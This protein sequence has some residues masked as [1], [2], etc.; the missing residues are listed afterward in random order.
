M[1][2]VFS[3]IIIIIICNTVV[4]ISVGFGLDKDMAETAPVD[5]AAS[6]A[7]VLQASAGVLEAVLQE[8][9]SSDINND[10]QHMDGDLTCAGSPP[11]LPSYAT[12]TSTFHD[13]HSKGLVMDADLFNLEML[14]EI[15]A[16]VSSSANVPEWSPVADKSL[17]TVTAGSNA[18]M[19]VDDDSREIPA[20]E[21]CS[22]ISCSSETIIKLADAALAADIVSHVEN[23]ENDAP[24]LRESLSLPNIDITDASHSVD[25]N[26]AFTTAATTTCAVNDAGNVQ[27]DNLQTVGTTT[28]FTPSEGHCSLIADDTNYVDILPVSDVDSVC[29]A[30]VVST[31]A[32]TCLTTIDQSI[33]DT[34]TVEISK[35]NI[36]VTE[37]NVVTSQ[38]AA[39]VLNPAA[40]SNNVSKKPPMQLSA[41][42]MKSAV[43]T[44][45][46]PLNSS[47]LEEDLVPDDLAVVAATDIDS[48]LAL[49]LPED[50]DGNASEL[51]LVA[52]NDEH[53]DNNNVETLA[54]KDAVEGLHSDTFEGIADV[55]LFA[56]GD[57]DKE[58]VQETLT[59][60]FVTYVEKPT[61][62]DIAIEPQFAADLRVDFVAMEKIE[63]LADKSL[64][65]DWSKCDAC[66]G[67]NDFIT[68]T[69]RSE[70]DA[71][72][73]VRVENHVISN[74]SV[75][76]A[77]T[78]TG[79]SVDEQVSTASLVVNNETCGDHKERAVVNVKQQK[80]QSSDDRVVAFAVNQLPTEALPPTPSPAAAV[81]QCPNVSQTNISCPPTAMDLP[82]SKSEPV[83][84]ATSNA[85]RHGGATGR[86]P[87]K[88]SGS[89]VI[90]LSAAPTIIPLSSSSEG[91]ST[92]SVA[93]ELLRAQKLAML[94]VRRPQPAVNHFMNSPASS[95]SPS[96]GKNLV[97]H[98][99]SQRKNGRLSSADN[100]TNREVVRRVDRQPSGVLVARNIYSRTASQHSPGNSR[101]VVTS[102]DRRNYNKRH[103]S[104]PSDSRRRRQ[105]QEPYVS[106]DAGTFYDEEEEDWLAYNER[107]VA[108]RPP[109]PSNRGSDE[110]NSRPAGYHREYYGSNE[111]T[112]S[113]GHRGS[114][115]ALSRRHR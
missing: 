31:I 81:Q 41:G 13:S 86:R 72:V 52:H 68:D 25:N 44:D 77:G 7:D 111:S 109:L 58:E 35:V 113:T 99:A 9:V 51:P 80:Q 43:A 2:F 93:E 14:D 39:A 36:K 78:E 76:A 40:M 37:G 69:S 57:I 48:Y 28:A 65:A 4:S 88:T 66:E 85:T 29:L 42:N 91:T 100:Q 83:S 62:G 46:V 107:L 38:T 74:T 71:S 21:S 79:T 110:R 45:V 32:D 101:S 34:A 15:C 97:G 60:M 87:A 103:A 94:S 23:M 24:S 49:L 3:I 8:P 22:P 11:A 1:L 54:E 10:T 20:D 30:A 33:I 84:T 82:S 67:G 59:D 106:S 115:D 12:L 64:A 73:S 98:E 56:A 6:S 63:S 55:V 108:T 27:G 70:Q 95:A 50:T 112:G 19:V 75:A 89:R 17:D 61:R 53:E 92:E 5:P 16:K 105:E 18:S 96:A 104:P 47:A 26:L 114:N 90:P 102:E